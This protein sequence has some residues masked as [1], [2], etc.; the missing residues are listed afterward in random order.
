MPWSD[1]K[2]KFAEP[3]FV[4]IEWG[5]RSGILLDKECGPVGQKS[6]E[7]SLLACLAR[8]VGP[9]LT[10]RVG[11]LAPDEQADALKAMQRP[12]LFGGQ[13]DVKDARIGVSSMLYL[14]VLGRDGTPGGG[15]ELGLFD[16]AT[17]RR[18][19]GLNNHPVPFRE[20]RDDEE[21][22]GSDAAFLKAAD[23]AGQLRLRC[24]GRAA[25]NLPDGMAQLSKTLDA[26]YKDLDAEKSRLANDLLMRISPAGTRLPTGEAKFKDLPQG[27]RD[28]AARNFGAAWQQEGF[29]SE[30]EAQTYLQASAGVQVSTA[31]NIEF[32][33]RSSDPTHRVA[34]QLGMVA[35]ASVDGG[36][37]P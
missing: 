1:F 5:K 25:S 17:A 31:I 10:V 22:R 16:G 15:K 8:S 23:D 13:S 34:E 19:Q 12:L 3:R 11:D 9:D 7:I 36:I 29:A 4:L 6:H 21:K 18:Q 32:C 33:L 26:I 14:Q 2:P 27:L 35:I 20:P 30:L 37:S 28:L 24:F